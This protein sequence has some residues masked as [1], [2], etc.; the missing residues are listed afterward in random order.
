M[1]N[2]LFSLILFSVTCCAAPYSWKAIPESKENEKTI[3]V[4]SHGWHTGLILSYDSLTSLKQIEESLGY[5]PY[6]EFGWG[7][8]DFYQEEEITTGVTFKAIFWPTDSVMHVVP[9]SNNPYNHF[10][11]SEIIEVNLSQKGLIRLT[12]FISNSFYMDADK[13]F[14]M[15][16]QGIYEKSIFFKATGGYQITNTC[17]TWVAEALETSGVPVDSFLTLTADSVIRQTKKAV[18]EYKCCLD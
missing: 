9:V 10:P 1:R 6:Y 7:D 4:I 12:D 11:R 13:N 5:S 17:N 2:L 3:Y 14:L 15:L 8:A 16:G 18:L